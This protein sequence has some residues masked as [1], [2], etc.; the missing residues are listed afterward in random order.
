QGYSCL[1]KQVHHEADIVIHQYGQRPRAAVI[2]H[3]HNAKPARAFSGRRL[4][5][6]S[7]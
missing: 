2:L 7:N 1:V 3:C 6:P 4:L 5:S